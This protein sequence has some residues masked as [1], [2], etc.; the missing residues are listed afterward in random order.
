M[1]DCILSPTQNTS[2]ETV[3]HTIANRG[4]FYTFYKKLQKNENIPG[5]KLINFLGFW[6]IS[7]NKT[8][9]YLRKRDKNGNHFQRFD[10]ITKKKKGRLVRTDVLTRLII[11]IPLIF[12]EVHT[13]VF[14]VERVQS[15]ALGVKYDCFICRKGPIW[16][17]WGPRVPNPMAFFSH[18]N[19]IIAWSATWIHSKCNI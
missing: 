5:A 15:G 11:N 19:P 10:Q 16:S 18:K 3:F 8:F 12:E 13:T 17:P 7:K 4:T 9:F 6:H 1:M 14:Y 2:F